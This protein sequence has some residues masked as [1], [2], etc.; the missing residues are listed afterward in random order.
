[1]LGRAL[2]STGPARRGSSAANDL[3]LALKGA[4]LR[5]GSGGR[6]GATRRG[7]KFHL[8]PHGVPGIESRGVCEG[9][10]RQ[11]ARY[12]GLKVMRNG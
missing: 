1:M 9:R 8:T 7:S 11:D 5:R 6:A 3:S 4:A 10:E 2:T 12:A